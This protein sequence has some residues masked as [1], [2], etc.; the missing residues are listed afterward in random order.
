MGLPSL[1]E[2][3]G[4]LCVAELREITPEIDA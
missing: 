1:L 3:L 2:A 4:K